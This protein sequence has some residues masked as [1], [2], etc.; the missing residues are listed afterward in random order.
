MLLSRRGVAGC[1]AANKTLPQ[2]FSD[3]S[4]NIL[5]PSLSYVQWRSSDLVELND[6][7]SKG[8]VSVLPAVPKLWFHQYEF[9]RDIHRANG[10]PVLLR[11]QLLDYVTSQLKQHYD[12]ILFDCPP[13]FDTLTRAAL[14]ISDI[15][16]APTLADHTSMQSLK[17]FMDIGLEHTMKLNVANCVFV[18]VTKFQGTSEQTRELDVLRKTYRVV[19][20]PVPLRD[21]VVQ[22]TR[23]SEGVLRT[24]KDKYRRPLVRPL[25]PSVIQMADAVHNAIFVQHR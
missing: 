2:L 16:V 6:S 3:W 4:Q 17:D 12:C 9:D 11:A 13:G 24:Y 10:D 5:Q 20:S 19:G 22:A 18:T 7:S 1:A 23:R 8:Y 25:S 14:T 21:Q 15:V